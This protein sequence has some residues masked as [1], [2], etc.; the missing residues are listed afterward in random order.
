MLNSQIL[1]IKFTFK[2]K[3]LTTF[4]YKLGEMILKNVRNCLFKTVLSFLTKY[5][6]KL[7]NKL[8]I[9][10]GSYKRGGSF[11]HNGKILKWLNKKKNRRKSTRIK[12]SLPRA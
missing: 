3:P 11:N 10:I 1:K 8:L 12:L 5:N 2:V 4:P 6:Q 9:H 7:N